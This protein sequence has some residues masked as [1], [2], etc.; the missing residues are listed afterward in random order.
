MTAIASWLAVG[1]AVGVFAGWLSPDA[2]PAGRAGG[3]I[4]GAAGA[5]VGGGSVAMIAE[6]GVARVD[7][8]SL[9]VACLTAA[10][11]LAAI[12]KAQYAEPRPH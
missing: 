8:L 7:F 11:V 6:R 2:F 4:A 12:R 3:S 10:L 1:A 5:F 9:A